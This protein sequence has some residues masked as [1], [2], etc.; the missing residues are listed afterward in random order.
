[1][2]SS[3]FLPSINIC[4]ISLIG[5]ET[6][7]DG[8]HLMIS[9]FGNLHK[10]SPPIFAQT[11]V[12]TYIICN[13]LTPTPKKSCCRPH[14]HPR[15]LA[16]VSNFLNGQ[17]QNYR[18]N[19]LSKCPWSNRCVLCIFLIIPD[20][21]GKSSRSS[22]TFSGRVHSLGINIIYVVPPDLALS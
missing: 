22:W 13:A 14:R 21:Q 8:P 4:W 7:W 18:P 12:P 9:K 6:C 16:I 1:M 3:N 15:F 20:G 2:S 11:C 5:Y 17:P 19:P 10:N